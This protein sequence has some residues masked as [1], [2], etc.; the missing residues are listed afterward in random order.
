MKVYFHKHINLAFGANLLSSRQH[1]ER[2]YQKLHLGR[3]RM[4]S[5]RRLSAELSAAWEETAQRA[6]GA[7]V[8]R[9]LQDLAMQSSSRAVI[10]P[11]LAGG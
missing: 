6:E 2:Q 8:L 10:G 11:P 1:N 9:S 3:F 4:G 7:S 5:R